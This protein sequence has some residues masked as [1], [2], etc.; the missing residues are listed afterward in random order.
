[1]NTELAKE[2][3][4]KYDN[5]VIVALEEYFE[6]L[7]ENGDQDY[8]KIKQK[9]NDPLYHIKFLDALG[10]ISILLSSAVIIEDDGQYNRIKKKILNESRK[11]DISIYNMVVFYVTN[12][13]S[14]VVFQ[15]LNS[16]EQKKLYSD[17]MID[18]LK[19][20]K[21]QLIFLV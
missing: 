13:Q 21:E 6:L 7:K 18:F 9:I 12:Y 3:L 10:N 16:E 5:N 11:D 15:T 4:S 8:K 1:M 19:T 2:E 14:F 17:R 20:Y